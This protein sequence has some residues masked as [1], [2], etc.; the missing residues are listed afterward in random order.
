MNK[1]NQVLLFLRKASIRKA[2]DDAI[3]CCGCSL[4]DSKSCVFFFFKLEH[5]FLF[6]GKVMAL[7]PILCKPKEGQTVFKRHG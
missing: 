2:A 6:N 7:V 4:G 1:Q 3:Q 5:V